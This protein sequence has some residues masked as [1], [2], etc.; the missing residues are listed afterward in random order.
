M[1]GVGNVEKG[2]ELSVWWVQSF[3]LEIEEKFKKW[4]I[5]RIEQQCDCT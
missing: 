4:I 5:V 1:S 2:R 3:N